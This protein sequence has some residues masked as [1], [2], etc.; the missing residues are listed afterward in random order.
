MRESIEAAFRLVAGFEKA[1]LEKDEARYA[2]CMYRVLVVAEAANG[3]PDPLL[4]R[5]PQIPWSELIGMGHMLRHQHFRI[6]ADVV[7]D[8]IKDDFPLLLKTVKRMLEDE[9]AEVR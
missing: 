1:A 8:T 7:W 5:Y 2:A 6:E 3:L 4:A 9:M